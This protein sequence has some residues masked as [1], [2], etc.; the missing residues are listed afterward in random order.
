[1]HRMA[2]FL[3]LLLLVSCAA[4]VSKP[5]P[6]VPIAIEDPKPAT[7]ITFA[8]NNDD[9]VVYQPIISAFN[10]QYQDVQVQF[11]AIDPGQDVQQMVH[12]ADTAAVSALDASALEA[13]YLH[14]ISSLIEADASFD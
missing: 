3:V 5:I 10:T 4:D 11:I 7:I 8:A 6:T 9:K 2:L 14:D 12:S 1:M 13:G